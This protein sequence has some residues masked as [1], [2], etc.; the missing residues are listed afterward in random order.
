MKDGFLF[1]LSLLCGLLASAG[2]LVLWYV[3]LSEKS[4]VS[5]LTSLC[6]VLPALLGLLASFVKPPVILLSFIVSFP[7]SLYLSMNADKFSFFLIASLLYLLSAVLKGR[8]AKARW[9]P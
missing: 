8:T 3:L 2:S 5:A 9:N 4:S 1:W 6:L 7:L